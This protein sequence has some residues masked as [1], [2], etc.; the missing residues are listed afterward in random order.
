ML[1]GAALSR[2]HAEAIVAR[3]RRAGDP[4]RCRRSRTR[5]T[6]RRRPFRSPRSAPPSRT[7][8]AARSSARRAGRRRTGRTSRCER[9]AAAVPRALSVRELDLPLCPAAGRAAR[10]QARGAAAAGTVRQ[11]AGEGKPSRYAVGDWVR[12]K[13]AEAIRATLDQHDTLR[14]MAFTGR[15]VVVLRQD[16]PRRRRRPPDHERLR[17]ACARSGAPSRSPARP[18]TARTRGRLRPGL[19]AAVPRRMARTVIGGPRR[20]AAA[21]GAPCASRRSTRFARRSRRT[22]AATASCSSRRWRSTRARGYRSPSASSRSPRRGGGPVAASGT[23]SPAHAAAANPG[24]RRPVP[25]R[26]RLPVAQRLVGIRVSFAHRI[27]RHDP[28]RG[29]AFPDIL[30]SAA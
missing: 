21:S 24:R 26:L 1:T 27:P 28:L 29:S 13:D 15:A 14:G 9:R 11:R 2:Y 23:S 22:A 18:A 16:V 6:D 3:R 7:R 17:R 4:E 25:P 8:A 5:S 10:A 20:A 12:V 30:F 19:L